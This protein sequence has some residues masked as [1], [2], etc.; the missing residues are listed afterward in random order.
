MRTAEHCLK[1]DNTLLRYSETLS[2]L[3]GFV[4]RLLLIKTFREEAVLP[5][6]GS[7]YEPL[8]CTPYKHRQ[9]SLKP[10]AETLC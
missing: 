3:L 5:S 1:A 8:C 6:A 10:A 4:C 7:L 2:F 9:S